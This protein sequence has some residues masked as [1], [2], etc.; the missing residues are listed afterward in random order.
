MKKKIIAVN[1]IFVSTVL[2]LIHVS[3]SYLFFQIIRAVLHISCIFLYER[4]GIV[5]FPLPCFELAKFESNAPDYSFGY[6]FLRKLIMTRTI[7]LIGEFD[8][9]LPIAE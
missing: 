3:H 1:W 5:T 4:K 8:K 9:T 7:E 2:T 6:S